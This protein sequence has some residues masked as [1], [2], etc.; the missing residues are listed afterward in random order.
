M[1]GALSG[2]KVLDLSRLLPG[3]FC[4]MLMA[5]LEAEGKDVGLDTLSFIHLHKTAKLIAAS[6]ESGAVMAMA[7]EE[8]IARLSE[9]GTAIGLAFQ[10]RDDILDVEGNQAA[11]G[12]ST[13][14][15]KKRGKATYPRIVGLERSRRIQRELVEKA[16]AALE[17]FDSRAEPLR[18]IAHYI[19]ER[20]S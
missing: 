13:G 11:M 7:P 15:D 6:V 17:S 18:A 9:Y 16:L 12:K 5:D 14:S 1:T 2:I 4:S 20:G 10:I 3:P 8:S 19:I